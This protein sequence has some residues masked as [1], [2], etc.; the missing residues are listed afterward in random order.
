MLLRSRTGGVQSVWIIG[1]SLEGD[2]DLTIE[3][4]EGNG[5]PELRAN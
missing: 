2:I 3:D 1:I 4:T 5:T